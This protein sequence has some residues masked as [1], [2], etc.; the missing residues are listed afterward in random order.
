MES[1]TSTPNPASTCSLLAIFSSHPPHCYT[2]KLQATLLRSDAH[3]WV[4]RHHT[5]YLS[6]FLSLTHTPTPRP[7]SRTIAKDTAMRLNA[8]PV[9]DQ[10]FTDKSPNMYFYE[11][12][13][14]IPEVRKRSIGGEVEVREEGGESKWHGREGGREEWGMAMADDALTLSLSGGWSWHR[15]DEGEEHLP[16]QGTKE[17]RQTNLAPNQ[18]RQPARACL[19]ASSPD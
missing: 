15:Q 8:K 3:R 4:L 1:T 10:N 19:L 7:A 16:K 18:A 13:F 6:L 12:I 9:H 5:H 17:G 14:L 2:L 11:I